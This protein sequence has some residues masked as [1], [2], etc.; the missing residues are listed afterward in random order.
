MPL[1][2]LLDQVVLELAADHGADL[3]DLLGGRAKP[4]E[5]RNQRGM[6]GGGDRQVRYRARRQHR[7][8]PIVAIAGFE[9]RLGQFFNE[10]RHAVGA[11][12]DLVNGLSGEAGFASKLLDQRRAFTPIEPVQRQH[13]HMA[14]AAPRVPKLGAESDDDEHGQP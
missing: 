11:L 14:L 8:D 10:Q 9:H 13:C 12:D 6:Q 7:D 5:A 2:H 3:P 1:R 4:I